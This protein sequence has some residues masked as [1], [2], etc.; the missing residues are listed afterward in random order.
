MS[1]I[2][3][4][5]A[6]CPY[7][8]HTLLLRCWTSI[9]V[10][11]N[12]ELR[13]QV[14]S[15]DLFRFACPICEHTVSVE[16]PLY[17]H[18]P[19]RRFM[20]HVVPSVSDVEG[21]SAEGDEDL[22][23]SFQG[24]R[25]RTVV[26]T[27]RLAEKIKIFE[28]GLDDFVVEMFKLNIAC[29]L[30]VI[31]KVK[32]LLFDEM[33]DN[34]MKIC[35]VDK[36]TGDAVVINGS[37]KEF[38]GFQK[39]RYGVAVPKGFAFV[40]VSNIRK[41]IGTRDVVS[42][43]DREEMANLLVRIAYRA[44]EL[45]YLIDAELRIDED[46]M[47]GAMDFVV[48]QIPEIERRVPLRGDDWIAV[49]KCVGAR[50][51]IGM[52]LG[53]IAGSAWERD[54]FCLEEYGLQ[55]VTVDRYG[56]DYIHDAAIGAICK[57]EFD[58]LSHEVFNKMLQDLMG[59]IVMD[60]YVSKDIDWKNLVVSEYEK[61]NLLFI[62]TGFVFGVNYYLHHPTAHSIEMGVANNPEVPHVRL[63]RS[64]EVKCI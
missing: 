44:K 15:G 52:V 20:I 8:G 59:V 62:L 43:F 61:K 33:T 25:Y 36:K 14:I 53:I 50:A 22:S 18:D 5:S 6:D 24:Y 10:K 57:R 1:E 58:T 45:H 40:D 38:Y 49:K 7:C 48:G 31:Q 37:L 12:P 42:S 4:M 23:M 30:D 19:D 54:L 21:A 28:R 2:V 47:R 51:A 32:P 11:E 41:Y 3:D 29:R 64:V 13:A 35:C 17:Y 16:Y 34:E 60:H 63:K 46:I 39:F 27:M 56:W 26:G 55:Y 9:N